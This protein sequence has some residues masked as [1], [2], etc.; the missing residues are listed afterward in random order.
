MS[1]FETDDGIAH[2]LSLIP[3]S[4]LSIPFPIKILKSLTHSLASITLELIS[5]FRSSSRFYPVLR[6][7]GTPLQYSCLENPMHGGAW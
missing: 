7:D 4:E 5:L 6:S 1:Q 3:D 2:P